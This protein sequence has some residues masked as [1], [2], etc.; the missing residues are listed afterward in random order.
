MAE[1]KEK[2]PKPAKAEKTPI[3]IVKKKGGHGGHHGGAWKVAY[4]DFV[5]AMMAFFLVMWLVAQS[6][7]VKQ[8]VAKYF[9]D[10]ADYAA[11]VKAG[12][13]EG[14]Q[15]I[16]ENKESKISVL[17]QKGGGPWPEE[18]ESQ[19]QNLL[20]KAGKEIAEAIEK[21]AN[22]KEISKNVE[23]EITNEGLRIQLIEAGDS[24]FFDSGSAHLTQKG[25][26]AMA[27]IAKIVGNLNMDL[28][29]EGHTDSRPFNK[30]G[31]TNWELSADRANA[32]RR[33]LES[34]GVNPSHIKEVR[35]YADTRP[36]YPAATD[37][38]NRR[39]SIIVF[40]KVF[41]QKMMKGVSEPRLINRKPT[42]GETHTR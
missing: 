6:E 2:P 19:I 40:N 21:Q 31:Y 9:E 14:G 12:L 7:K 24:A 35:G 26:E 23:I 8:N 27:A 5:T 28:A 29:V 16:M 20:E 38:R 4:A 13:L 42:V 34:S 17:D 32:A 15:G 30:N 1:E 18:E 41:M 11:K 25:V 22:L 37:P 3:I 39:V 36:R 10:P 33:L